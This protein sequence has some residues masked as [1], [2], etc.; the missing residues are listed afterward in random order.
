[1]KRRSRAVRGDSTDARLRLLALRS[2][3]V[4]Q[5]QGGTRPSTQNPIAP[6]EYQSPPDDA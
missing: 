3:L 4:D 6:I 5:I 2:A 1:M